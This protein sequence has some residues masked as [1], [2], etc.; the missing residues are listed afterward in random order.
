MYQRL[1]YILSIH[2]LAEYADAH[3]FD[4]FVHQIYGYFKLIA[5]VIDPINYYVLEAGPLK[6]VTNYYNENPDMLLFGKGMMYRFETRHYDLVQIFNYKVLIDEYTQESSD[7]YI[8][9]F[10]EQ[11]G[12]VGILLLIIIFF[13]LPYLKMNEYN[14]HHVLILNAF[15]IS[16]LHY[17]PAQSPIFMIF[18]GYSIY[19][20]FFIPKE[21]K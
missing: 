6:L 20:L 2:H 7:F 13:V 14:I 9:N 16:T 8:L 19:A 10:F 18:V 11:F 21:S 5:N 4:L 12:I 15:I 1:D 17:S 3:P